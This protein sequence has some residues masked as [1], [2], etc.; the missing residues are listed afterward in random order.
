MA[1]IQHASI[2]DN[3]RH[4]PKGISSAT[5][6]QV[7]VADGSASGAWSKVGPISL[8]GV[9]TNGVAGQFVA[10][11]GTGNF[12]LASAAHG[13]CYFYNIG[14]PYILTYPATFTKLAPTTTASGDA[15]L[16]TEGTNARLT[17]VGTAATDLDVVFG[18]SVDQASG[19]DRDIEVALY[20]NGTLVPGS[21]AIAT[22]ESGKKIII[23]C[24]TDVPVV[25][26]DYLEVYA[27]NAGASG[28]IRVYTFKLF[29][30]TA[31]A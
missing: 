10:V 16:I 19:A 29:A 12:V 21:N 30:T 26:N 6:K 28:D 14:S 27:K 4:E 5:N 22:T 24:H 25:L 17:Y 31:G 20:K 7:Y 18:L 8:A 13:S 1:T 2:P 23:S 3:Q 15:T 9:S 11:D